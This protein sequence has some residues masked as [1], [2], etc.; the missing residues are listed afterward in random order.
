MSWWQVFRR[1]LKTIFTDTALLVT[2][3]GGVVMYSFLYPQPYIK[4]LPREQS[5]VVVNLDN[6]STSRKLERM[7]DA[8]PQVEIKQHAYSLEEAK[9]QFLSGEVHGI[10]VIP[11]HFNRDLLLGLSPTLAYAGDAAYFLIYGT[12]VEGLATA[13][14]TLSAQAKVA[15]MVMSG[16]NLVLASKQYTPIELSMQP[17]FNPSNGYIHY[18]VP[19]VFVLILHQTLLVAGGL[20]GAGRNELTQAGKTGYWHQQAPL[21]IWSARCLILVLMYIPLAMYYFGF[22]F[23]YYQISRLANMAEMLTIMLPFLVATASLAI[24]IG[25]LLPRRELATVIVVASS[26]PLVFSAGFVWPTSEL[27][28]LLQYL[29]QLAPSTA[30]INAF[31]RINQMGASLEQV[32]PYVWQLTA[33]A[34]VYGLLAIILIGKKASRFQRTAQIKTI[35]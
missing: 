27:P 18:I 9:Q 8:T 17:V 6:T 10:L 19:A 20:V 5:I 32:L 31:L 30:G 16:D 28:Q 15:R 2:V 29:A 12:I 21:S 35:D 11:R 26:L 22:S 3:F 14:G 24:L 1:E 25:E 33:Q 7:V 13:G 23:N 4:Q 34:L